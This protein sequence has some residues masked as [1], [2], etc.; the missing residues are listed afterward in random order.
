MVENEMAPLSLRDVGLAQFSYWPMI[1]KKVLANASY[2]FSLYNV[3]LLEIYDQCQI[4]NSEHKYWLLLLMVMTE[5]RLSQNAV[6]RAS[7]YCDNDLRS[8]A[9][10]LRTI[11]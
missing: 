8:I 11:T 9:S 7:N 5:L 1:S 10:A 2:D 3:L 4:E 6:L